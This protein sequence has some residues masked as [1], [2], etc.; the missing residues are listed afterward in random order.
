MSFDDEFFLTSLFVYQILVYISS[1]SLNTQ[2]LLASCIPC[3]ASYWQLLCCTCNSIVSFVF[4]CICLSPTYEL[5]LQTGKVIEN[6]AKFMSGIS[7][8]MAV[9]GNRGKL[10]IHSCDD[11][12]A[13]L[14]S[15]VNAALTLKHQSTVICVYNIKHWCELSFIWNTL[16][17]AVQ[18]SDTESIVFLSRRLLYRMLFIWFIHGCFYHSVL[19]RNKGC[20]LCLPT[21]LCSL[22]CFGQ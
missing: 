17:W 21:K 7:I 5:A 8:R 9:R 3:P 13:D 10:D 6:M 4:Q 1:A 22:L 11:W 15:C 16:S 19:G 12:L 2:S 14:S 20:R 18:Y